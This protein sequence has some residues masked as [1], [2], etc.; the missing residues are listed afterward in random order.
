MKT[1]IIQYRKEGMSLRATAQRL[2]AI[3][4]NKTPTGCT[5]VSPFGARRV[6]GRCAANAGGGMISV[7]LI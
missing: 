5:V 2:N 7:N 1:M 6:A 4:A 3:G